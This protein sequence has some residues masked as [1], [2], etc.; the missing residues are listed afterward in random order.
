MQSAIRNISKPKGI[1][2][3]ARSYLAS[4]VL[5]LLVN[6]ILPI[7][8]TVPALDGLLSVIPGLSVVYEK[9]LG[10]DTSD[11][12]NET[13]EDESAFL[14]AQFFVYI[15]IG[16]GFTYV[17]LGIA[18]SSAKSWS[19]KL[20]TSMTIIFSILAVFIGDLSLYV[21]ELGADIID[22]TTE[23]IQSSTITDISSIDSPYIYTNSIVGSFLAIFNKFIIIGAVIYPVIVE[24]YLHSSNVEA[25]FN[26]KAFGPTADAGYTARSPF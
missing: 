17:I 26:S 16:I 5:I 23:E 15:L 3:L 24:R 20:F 11:Y 18:L 10:I 9:A 13:E 14:W 1:K 6:L 21:V 2:F 19:I 25:Y 8:S 12:I 22:R 4:G 7:A